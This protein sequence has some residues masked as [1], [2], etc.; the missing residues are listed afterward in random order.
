MTKEMQERY[1]WRSFILSAYREKDYK[2]TLELM[3]S[4]VGDLGDIE[5]LIDGFTE[6]A[7]PADG[8]RDLA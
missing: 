3:A 5:M 1:E 4:N 8:W 2:K 6:N 7:S